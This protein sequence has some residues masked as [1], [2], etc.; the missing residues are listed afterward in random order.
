M[1]YLTRAMGKPRFERIFRKMGKLPPADA[2][3]AAEEPKRDD[4]A[5]SAAEVLD[6]VDDMKAD[7]MSWK[8]LAAKALAPDEVPNKKADIIKA[9]EAKIEAEKGT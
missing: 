6:L 8:A 2:P 4:E 9:L 3:K 7:F 1:S 5:M